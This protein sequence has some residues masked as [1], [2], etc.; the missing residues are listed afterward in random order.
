MFHITSCRLIH[1]K[2]YCLKDYSNKQSPQKTKESKRK[3]LERARMSSAELRR[4]YGSLDGKESLK[5]ITRESLR[6]SLRSTGFL[7]KESILRNAVTKP[8]VIKVGKKLA[9]CIC[10]QS[11]VAS[12]N[13]HLISRREGHDSRRVCDCEVQEW[14][15]V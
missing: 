7:S 3:S 11:I 5:R 8:S 15:C 12:E 6:S 13:V 14:K 1:F 2:L 4:S 9:S 10:H